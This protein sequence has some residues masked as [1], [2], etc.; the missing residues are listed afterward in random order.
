MYGPSTY[1]CTHTHKA[2]TWW[3]HYHIVTFISST[4]CNIHQKT[5]IVS[6]GGIG[7]SELQSSCCGIDFCPSKTISRC[8]SSISPP[9][10]LRLWV[11][12]VIRQVRMRTQQSDYFVIT[13]NISSGWKEELSSGWEGVETI[14]TGLLIHIYSSTYH[15][16]GKLCIVLVMRLCEF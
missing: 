9:T 3:F 15:R 16:N 11:Y 12:W 5:C 13:P 10:D 1:A 4:L 8:S 2:P 7:D 14:C 6:S